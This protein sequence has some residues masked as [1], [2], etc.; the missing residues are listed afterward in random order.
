MKKKKLWIALL[1]AFVVL[2][3]SVVY[4]NRAVIFQ[5]GN[6]IPYLTAAARISE[7]NPYVAVDEAKGI[8]I[9]K[10]GECPELLEYYQE[11]TGMEFVEQAGSSYLF[12]DG[13][14]SEVASS[15]VY[16]GRYT[17]WVLPAM[18]AAESF[19]AEQYD[20]KPVIYLYPEKK[21]EVTV[22]LNYAG[23]LTCTYPAYN[24]GWKV[25]ASPDGTLTDADGQTYN[26]LYWEGVNSVV[27]D[28]S[29]GFCVAGS[30]TAAFLENALNQLGLTRKEA[31]EFIVYWLPLMK[32]NPYN[33][34][35]FQSDSYTQTA[36]LSIEP[37][38]DTLL[39]VFMAWKPLESAVDISTQNLTAPVRTGFTAVEWGGCQ[40]R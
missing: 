35:A 7:K 23:E 4:L 19:D 40:V 31:N 6:P 15:E 5:R 36:Q 30:D 24:D 10:R 38:P 28:F 18:E 27:Y 33:L 12:T 21:A 39:R 1:V 14:R 13:S 29:E 11:K 16:W 26:Y 25:C 32:G 37:V 3:A 20:A 22:K 2:A 9:S 17:V 8:Y 34:I